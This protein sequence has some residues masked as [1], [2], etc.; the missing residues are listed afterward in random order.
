MSNS[1][2]DASYRACRRLARRTAGNFFVSFLGLSRDR[3]RGMCAL[4]A[5]LRLSDDLG[6]EPGW[7]SR[8]RQERLGAWRGHLEMA[9][10]GPT[11]P[12]V[13]PV[14]VFPALA[15]TVARFRIP[16]ETLGEVLDGIAM[17]LVPRTYET[18]EDL[19]TYCDRVAGAV[20]LCCLHI[21][22]FHDQAAEETALDCGMALQL[23]NIL[24]DLHEDAAMGRV[25]LPQEDLRRFA[26]TADDL[27]A[28]RVDGGFRPMMRFEVERTRAYYVAAEQ[29]FEQIDRP[30]RP[31]LRAMLTIYGAMLDRIEQVDYNVFDH[32]IRVSTWRKVLAGFAAVLGRG[33]RV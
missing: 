21:W 18:I 4:Y 16:A 1:R 29:L 12:R 30:G 15:D 2:L 26:V 22:G 6:D 9:L 14:D 5:F 13:E 33:Q 28:G 8:E 19:Q 7:S 32:P 20:G 11:V 31:V 10:D 23:T 3:F 27:V 24:R 25:Y 17:D